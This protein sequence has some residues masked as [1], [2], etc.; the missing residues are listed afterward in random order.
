VLTHH[1]ARASISTPP[2]VS[3]VSVGLVRTGPIERHGHLHEIA[4]VERAFP[5]LVGHDGGVHRAG[6][7]GVDSN[8]NQDHLTNG[9]LT[10]L[11]FDDLS[12]LSHRADIRHCRESPLGG[13]ESIEPSPE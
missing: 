4:L 8:R 7:R 2:R 11:V 10:W 6:P 13:V 3:E 1:S 9:T 5:G 12:M